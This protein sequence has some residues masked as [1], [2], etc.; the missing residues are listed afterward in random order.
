MAF[1]HDGQRYATAGGSDNDVRVWETRT[2]ALLFSRNHHPGASVPAV[3]FSPDDRKLVSV[4]SDLTARLWDLSGVDAS[5]VLAGHADVLWCGVFAPDGK[6][7]AT[8]GKDSTVK[9]WT[10]PFVRA[11]GAIDPYIRHCHAL[12]SSAEGR[13]L[14]TLKDAGQCERWDADSGRPLEA[15]PFRLAGGQ[16]RRH[17]RRDQHVSRRSMPGVRFRLAPRTKPGHGSSFPARR[18]RA[19]V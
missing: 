19:L 10:L 9:L 18:R 1:S 2:G 12:G 14:Y 7:L 15:L 4:G 5:A 8:T 11:E 13:Y 17:F 16:S 3:A 6:T